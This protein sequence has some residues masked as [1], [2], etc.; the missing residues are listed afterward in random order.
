MKQQ[1]HWK[2]IRPFKH[3]KKKLV[4]GETEQKMWSSNWKALSSNDGS[5]SCS[6]STINR[7][8]WEG[9]SY[10]SVHVSHFHIFF[11]LIFIF[12]FNFLF[13]FYVSSRS[14]WIQHMNTWPRRWWSALMWIEFQP[15]A[16]TKML[17]WHLALHV[18]HCVSEWLSPL[19]CLHTS[20][21]IHYV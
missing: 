16:D 2:S 18:W 20:Q 6:M 4:L 15:M 7:K 3:E 13:A 19:N 14:K 1:I 11:F 10:V 5:I 8:L 9:Y 21:S 17:D 12:F